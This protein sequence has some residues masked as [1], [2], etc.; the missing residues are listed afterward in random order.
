ML[1]VSLSAGLYTTYTASGLQLSVCKS[2]RDFHLM[3]L[4]I[5]TMYIMSMQACLCKCTTLCHNTMIISRV[6][7]SGGEGGG[8]RERERE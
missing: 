2:S 3:I 5:L 6:S 1:V 7:S 4:P 8:V